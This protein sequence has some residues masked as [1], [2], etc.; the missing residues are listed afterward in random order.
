MGKM[1]DKFE[2]YDKGKIILTKKYRAKNYTF[3]AWNQKS[4]NRNHQKLVFELR[5][6][7]LDNHGNIKNWSSMCEVFVPVL[8]LSH[9]KKQQNK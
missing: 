2:K 7:N 5:K 4:P 3:M 6:L 9:L 1:N 8:K